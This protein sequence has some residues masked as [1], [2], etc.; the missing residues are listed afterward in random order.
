MADR[1][2]DLE[3]LRWFRRRLAWL[4]RRYPHLKH[5]ESQERLTEALEH[6]TEE[7]IPCPANPL[8]TPE[9]AP[10]APGD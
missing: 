2:D 1:K 7:D 5:P 10:K 9:A 8:A 3:A 6:P 4:G